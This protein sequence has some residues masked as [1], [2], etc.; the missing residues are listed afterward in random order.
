MEDLEDI[1]RLIK[2]YISQE[3]SYSAEFNIKTG[4]VVRVG[5]SHGFNLENK[6]VISVDDEI[7][8]KIL[9]G[10]LS[11]SNCFVDIVNET[12]EII[13]TKSLSKLDDLLHR[14]MYIEHANIESPDLYVLYENNSLIVELS[15]EL[16][17]SYKLSKNLNPIKK[18]K[19]L[20]SGDTDVSFLLTS[21]NDPHIVFDEYQ[22]S[23]QDLLKGP[24]IF[25]DV[26]FSNNNSLYTKR[27]FKNYVMEIK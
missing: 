2:E 7:A 12:F 14:I 23:L 21:Y 9:S 17:G 20:W 22:C 4:R 18:R 19:L 27:L 26:K 13:E 3:V 24:V 5:P 8:E 10:G 25:D 6:N 16:G 1:G 15:E 11:I